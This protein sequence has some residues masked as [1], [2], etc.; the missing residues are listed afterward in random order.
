MNPGLADRLGYLGGKREATIVKF[1]LRLCGD[2]VDISTQSAA[3]NLQLNQMLSNW[4]WSAS[5]ILLDCIPPS[6]I[7]A[8][9]TIREGDELLSVKGN[10]QGIGKKGKFQFGRYGLFHEALNA[11]LQASLYWEKK[12]LDTQRTSSLS[13]RAGTARIKRPSS[14]HSAD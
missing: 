12:L 9:Y 3:N 1:N 4:S 14:K 11:R 13:E 5:E 10:D 2:I 7:V 8:V 6:S